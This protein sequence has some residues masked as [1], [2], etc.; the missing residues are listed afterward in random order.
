MKHLIRLTALLAVLCLIAGCAQPMFPEKSAGQS[1]IPAPELAVAR[2]SKLT[3]TELSRDILP[4]GRACLSGAYLYFLAV[5]ATSGVAQT[6]LYCVH[7]E[8]GD[9]TASKPL[10]A[11]GNSAVTNAA[12]FAGADSTA[13]LAQTVKTVSG[14]EVQSVTQLLQYSPDGKTLTVLVLE[15]AYPRLS[16]CLAWQDRLILAT[17]NALRV[18]GTDGAPGPV[19]ST[20]T[21]AMALVLYGD[22]PAALYETDTGRLVLRTLSVASAKLSDPVSLP[23]SLSA[24]NLYSN[25]YDGVFSGLG[26]SIV[27]PCQN[28]LFLCAP[29]KETVQRQTDWL[30]HGIDP[31]QIVY[32]TMTGADTVAALYAEELGP[33][34]LLL[35][36]PADT[37]TETDSGLTL[38]LLQPD[39]DIYALVTN[40][41]REAET[42]IRII[43]YGQYAA[44]GKSGYTQLRL[45]LARGTGPDLLFSAD[46]DLPVTE[47]AD[48][49][50]ADLYPYLKQD[51]ALAQEGLL[52]SVLKLQE[53]DGQLLSV[54]PSFTLV[55]ALSR[56][57]L[58]GTG[59]LTISRAL[60]F[61]DSLTTFT[62]S[63][64]EDFSLRE[65]IFRE[66]ISRN[67][68]IYGIGEGG[69][70]RF[71]TTLL[72]EGL[73]YAARFP[74]SIDWE[75]YDAFG[76]LPGWVRVRKG[77]QLLLSGTYYGFSAL[78]QDLYAIGEGALICGLPDV[79]GGHSLELWQTCGMTKTCRDPEAAWQFIRLLLLAEEQCSRSASGFPTN[80]TAFARKGQEAMHAE[81]TRTLSAGED[82]LTIPAQL[83]QAQYDQILAAVEK[84][85]A[86]YHADEEVLD[87]VWTVAQEYFA[88][89]LDLSTAAANAQTAAKNYHAPN[90]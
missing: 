70:F 48:T 76:S 57:A 12:L 40:F 73:Q 17:E 51:A 79:V 61:Y 55:T 69:M 15:Q 75:K 88:G 90:R 36:T 71:N 60:N 8:T 30:S 31:L 1:D 49:F 13:W 81:G 67:S 19:I 86:R 78:S 21:P 10:T 27:Y 11:D 85:S 62:T 47:L 53:K 2:Q 80:R 9:M 38:G 7:T 72:Q 65:E 84:A 82:T 35:L 5:D 52:E 3:R 54:A 16:A 18:Y 37:D 46:R 41:N 87:A 43:N 66:H 20:G 58:T 4:A 39:A 68:N 77:E 25:L 6:R 26:R 33:L 45:A 56:E 63:A 50:L 34:Q 14:T 23:F 32:Q 29:E 44:F 74:K 64:L 59:T 22:A 28:D 89:R 42:P 24:V 83:S